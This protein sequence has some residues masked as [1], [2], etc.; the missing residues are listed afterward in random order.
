MCLGRYLDRKMITLDTKSCRTMKMWHLLFVVLAS[1][2]SVA[3]SQREMPS[4][5]EGV[6]RNSL[7]RPFSEQAFRENLPRARRG[8]PKAM[9]VLVNYYLERDMNKQA[10]YW[11]DRVD[12]FYLKR[13][14][15]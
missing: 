15:R 3:C 4:P 11:S 12:E 5:G 1:L 7:I 8:D 2:G 14:G 9:V 13:D 6:S 10:Q